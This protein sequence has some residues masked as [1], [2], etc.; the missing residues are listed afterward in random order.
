MIS[1]SPEKLTLKQKYDT[2]FS[3]AVLEHLIDPN[4]AIQELCKHLRKNGHLILLVDL[5]GESE[6]MP[7]HRNIDIHSLHDN[8]E[9]R[10]LVNE[11]GRN[12]FCSI[13]RKARVTKYVY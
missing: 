3:D 1:S 13:W 6:M 9:R 11:Y 5:S 8:I 12:T 7:V 2:I 4:K 10:G